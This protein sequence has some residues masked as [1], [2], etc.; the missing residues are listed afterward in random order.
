MNRRVKVFGFF[1]CALLSA[2]CVTAEAQ[3]AKKIPRIGYL[4]AI[5]RATEAT[6]IE[7]IRLA[8]RELGYIEGQSIA[9]EYRYADGNPARVTELAEELVRLKVDLI[10][11]TGGDPVIRA[12]KNATK[13]IPIVM[14][15]GG[16]EPVGAGFVES[17]ARPG[18]NITGLTN[19]STELTGKRLELL[20][21]A[22]P[23][24]ARVAVLY[25]STIPGNVLQLKD[26]S[27]RTEVDGPTIRG[28]RRRWF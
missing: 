1:L 17:L 24:I 7:A 21:G 26:H 15:G 25:D 3:Q 13:T 8:L 14:V 12:A 4:S 10:V 6:R 28:R 2:L 16:S 20:Q 11:A 5:D 22:V 18:G 27:A 19:L 23:K 9:T